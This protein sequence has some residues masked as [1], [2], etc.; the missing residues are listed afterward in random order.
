MVNAA[1]HA[2]L[3]TKLRAMVGATWITDAPFRETAEAIEAAR[4][5]QRIK[6]HVGSS[7]SIR[8][9]VD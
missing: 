6:D 2:I 7:F 5:Q 3:G 1:A 4:L 9:L 8:Y